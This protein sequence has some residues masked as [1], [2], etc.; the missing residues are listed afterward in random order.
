MV[1]NEQK[2]QKAEV[3][4]LSQ[5]VE[6]SE[7]QIRRSFA[8]K[9]R[10][11]DFT[12]CAVYEEVSDPESGMSQ[13]LIHITNPYEVDG[14]VVTIPTQASREDVE[15]IVKGI[16]P[17]PEFCQMLSKMAECYE[18]RYPLIIEGGTAVGK[19]YMVNKFTELLYGKG[20]KPLDFYCS[21]QTDV[22]DL[23]GK[24][25]PKEGTAPE[26]REKWEKFLRSE[27]GKK[28]LQQI[29]EGIAGTGEELTIQDKARMYQA[30]MRQLA[31]EAGLGSDSEFTF[32]LGAV[33]RAFTGEYQDGRFRVR[34]GAEGFILHVQEAGLAKPA[35]LNAL[36]RIRGEQGEIEENIQLWEDGGR[37]ISRGLKTFVVFTNNP[38]DG[39]LDRRAI[40][41]A[42]SRGL[43]WLR[44]GEGLSDKSVQMTARKIFTYD[45]GND[46]APKNRHSEFDFRQAS[47]VG[48]QI[49][50]AMVAIHTTLSKHFNQPGDDDP[51]MTPVVMD[52]MIK[53]A[54]IIQNHQVKENGEIHV[55]KTLM[56]AIE[57][58][59][60]ERARPGDR[61]GLRR[62][63]NE[64][65]FGS[66]G[67]RSFEGQLLSLSDRLQVLAK[68]SNASQPKPNLIA[69]SVAYEQAMEFFK[70]AKELVERAKQKNT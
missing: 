51:Q 26:V 25:V 31:T 59:Y 36:L 21:G 67:Q 65:I 2:N 45:L 3:T 68:R 40:D 42:L 18:L 7:E 52:N 38:V 44:F 14:P 35:V 62:Q 32:Q 47:E 58:T 50:T 66:T 48:Q 27:Q 64:E 12:K 9:D 70:R 10:F 11:G 8:E 54:K 61:D 39:Y 1:K 30:Q 53:V 22:S 28:R 29:D 19:T 63:V 43:E 13:G 33:P 37:A 41:P 56:R 16:S 24:W 55:G 5:E 49:A 60:L 23:I 46:F 6:L 20:I 4:Q 57:R 17:I 34:E 15:R 69:E